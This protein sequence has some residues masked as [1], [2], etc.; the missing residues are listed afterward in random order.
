[1]LPTRVATIVL[2]REEM[3]TAVQIE[4]RMGM[5]RRR[6][7]MSC[8]PA[9]ASEGD[10]ELMAPLLRGGPCCCCESRSGVRSDGVDDDMAGVTSTKKRTRRKREK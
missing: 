8:G 1:M 2:S 9:G 7:G 6:G 3:K 4:V 5:Y 10:E